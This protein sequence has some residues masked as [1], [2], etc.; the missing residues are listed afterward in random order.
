MY[1]HVPNLTGIAASMDIAMSMS[2]P[3]NSS[4]VSHPYQL[5]CTFIS[6]KLLPATNVRHSARR[7]TAQ[8]SQSPRSLACAHAAALRTIHL[9]VVYEISRPHQSLP[10]AASRAVH[11]YCRQRRGLSCHTAPPPSAGSGA[12]CLAPG[13]TG[14]P[15]HYGTT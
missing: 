15:R 13:R 14:T 1:H 2:V 12:R 5:T 9:A 10:S 7:H 6:G 11:R 4:L 3:L 8:P